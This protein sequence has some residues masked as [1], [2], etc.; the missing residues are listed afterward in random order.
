MGNANCVIRNQ[1]GYPIIVRTYNHFD[2]VNVVPYGAWLIDDGDERTVA[3]MPDH[4]GLK[5]SVEGNGV[6]I[7]AGVAIQG[8]KVTVTDLTGGA[9]VSQAVTPG[10]SHCIVRNDSPSAIMV[11]T[12]IHGE[13]L[14]LI[15]AATF[16][17]EVGTAKRIECLYSSRGIKLKGENGKGV[18]SAV[19]L[20]ANGETLVVSGPIVDGKPL[21]D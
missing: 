5:V 4:R 14:N 2:V 10:M 15:A 3:A 6:I 18:S 21:G 9:P 19:R 8:D 11:K 7:P 16:L 1:T 12:Y 13:I 20:V 17:V